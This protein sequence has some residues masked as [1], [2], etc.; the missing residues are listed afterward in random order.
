MIL[1]GPARAALVTALESLPAGSAAGARSCRAPTTLVITLTYDDGSERRLLVDYEGCGPRGVSE[2]G[3]IAKVDPD[4]V[5]AALEGS[6]YGWG[7]DNV[8]ARQR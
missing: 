8:I 6:S 5:R 7:Y 4:V 1:S 2:G 3:R